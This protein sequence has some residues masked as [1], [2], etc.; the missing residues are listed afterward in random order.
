MRGMK[1]NKIVKTL[2]AVAFAL[3]FS[4]CAQTGAGLNQPTLRQ[5]VGSKN[6]V[7]S[8]ASLTQLAA[9][10]NAQ[11]QVDYHGATLFCEGKAPTLPLSITTTYGTQTEQFWCQIYGYTNSSNQLIVPE[12][13]SLGLAPVAAPVSAPAVKN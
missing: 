3:A 4:A 7:P 12:S 5:Q 9:G 8:A 11:A 10:G 2:A 1:M 13:I 6:A